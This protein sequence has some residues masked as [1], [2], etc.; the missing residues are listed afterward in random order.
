M[1]EPSAS[2]TAF[3]AAVLFGLSMP[4]ARWLLADLDPV[5]LAGLLPVSA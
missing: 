3:A 1:S 4:C 2:S 5:L